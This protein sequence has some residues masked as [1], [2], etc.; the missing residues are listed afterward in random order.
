MVETIK[1]L[2]GT[3]F[4]AVF[5]Q[6]LVAVRASGR[7]FIDALTAAWTGVIPEVEF[8]G[9][10][11]IIIVFGLIHFSISSGKISQL[12]I[13]NMLLFGFKGKNLNF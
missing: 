6:I 4:V 5:H 2:D 3:L 9:H 11:H 7:D 1:F 12:C 8:H 13:E 10:N